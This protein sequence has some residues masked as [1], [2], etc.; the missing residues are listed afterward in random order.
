[1]SSCFSNLSFFSCLG[2]K[3][4]TCD[5]S[6]F[7]LAF[8]FP[9]SADASNTGS[10]GKG[11]TYYN[12]KDF[13]RDSD[14]NKWLKKLYKKSK[15]LNFV[16]F[17][18]QLTSMNISDISKGH[19]KGIIT[20]NNQKFSYLVHSVPN[21][22]LEFDG[23]DISDISESELLYGQSFLY[24]ECDISMLYDFYE[25][26]LLMKPNIYLQTKVLNA[27]IPKTISITEYSKKQLSKTLIHLSKHPSNKTDIYEYIANHYNTQIISETWLRGGLEKNCVDTDTVK[28]IQKVHYKFY[29]RSYFRKYLDSEVEYTY[30]TD[31]SKF[32]VSLDK[33]LI[34]IGD[35]NRMSTQ[36]TRGGGGIVVSDG[37]VCKALRKVM[38]F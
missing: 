5:S 25:N 32:A 20:W 21:F 29:K 36:F 12:G 15:W 24:I 11:Y 23:K 18:D 10:E 6:D 35:L 13:V 38:T 7:K 27:C 22:P 9:K 4:L 33:D 19:C 1:M 2:C 28:T 37:K 16:V 31:H 3:S 8:K 26:I 17:N 34:F 14:I 30:S